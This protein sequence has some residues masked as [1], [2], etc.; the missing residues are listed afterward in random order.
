MWREVFGHPHIRALYRVLPCSCSEIGLIHN[1][2]EHKYM[3]MRTFPSTNTLATALVTVS[4]SLLSNKIKS[5]STS[6]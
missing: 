5:K 2:T 1:R 6:Y 4:P 3:K